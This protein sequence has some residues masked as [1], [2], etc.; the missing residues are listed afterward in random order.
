MAGS[1]YSFRPYIRGNEMQ[2]SLPVRVPN[3][4]RRSGKHLGNQRSEYWN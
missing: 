2:M 1:K 3:T 4:R